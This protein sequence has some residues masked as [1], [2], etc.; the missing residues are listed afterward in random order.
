MTDT[1]GHCMATTSAMH[2]IGCVSR[3]CSAL[4][5]PMLSNTHTLQA[6][7]L[8]GLGV[9]PSARHA[10]MPTLR[11]SPNGSGNAWFT[12]S[13]FDCNEGSRLRAKVLAGH[14]HMGELWQLQPPLSKIDRLDGLNPASTS[15]AQLAAGRLGASIC[16][17]HC[18]PACKALCNSCVCEARMHGRLRHKCR[19]QPS[20]MLSCAAIA[21]AAADCLLVNSLRVA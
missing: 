15:P 3:S 6:D 14:R 21:A 9:T 16:P 11:C 17:P 12:I 10:V 18:P 5:D 1:T 8:H 19:L 7:E 20:S 2:C 13:V 4:L